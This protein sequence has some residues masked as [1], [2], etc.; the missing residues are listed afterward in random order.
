MCYIPYICNVINNFSRFRS[1]YC[2]RINRRRT[3][4][5]P[6]RFTHGFGCRGTQRSA[7]RLSRQ[8]PAPGM[9]FRKKVR[10]SRMD[11]DINSPSISDG[12]AVK[13]KNYANL[14]NYAKLKIFMLLIIIEIIKILSYWNLLLR[15]FFLLLHL[16]W[17][18]FIFYLHIYILGWAIA[19]RERDWKYRLSIYYAK[20]QDSGIYTCSTPKGLANSIRVRIIGDGHSTR[21]LLF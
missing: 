11:M 18:R 20:S 5:Y 15:Y 16:Y 8:H 17:E 10:Q 21:L 6:F 9:P 7:C 19:A 12:W 1:S 2:S 3:T 14:R 13:I 4:N